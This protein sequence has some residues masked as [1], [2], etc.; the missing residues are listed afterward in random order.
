MLVIDD[1]GQIRRVVH[2]AL[3][4]DGTRVIEA[5]SGREGI[6]MEAINRLASCLCGA[7]SRADSRFAPL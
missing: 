1:E 3:D 2:N 6:D 4:S 5:A 7:D